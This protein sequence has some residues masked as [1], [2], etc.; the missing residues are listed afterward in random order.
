MN[1]LT[2]TKHALQLAIM[3][4]SFFILSACSGISNDQNTPPQLYSD[5]S[6][7]AAFLLKQA[8]LYEGKESSDWQ[9]S[10]VQALTNEHQFMLAD[11]VIEHLQAKMLSPKQT[12]ELLLL[13]ADNHYAQNELVL[14]LSTLNRIDTSVLSPSAYLHFLKLNVTLQ[15]RN[16]NHQA[17]SDDLL[18]LTPLLTLD[19]EKQQ[20]NDL[21]LRELSLLDASVLN[22]FQ[23]KENLA[24]NSDGLLLDDSSNAKLEQ[25]LAEIEA[26]MD[27]EVSNAIVLTDDQIFVQ[28]W[29]ALASLYQQYQL[30]TN[31]LIRALD[32]WEQTYP[33]H[34]AL[35]FMPTQLRNIPEAAPYLPEKVAVLLPLSGRFSQSAQA[36]QYGISYAFYNKIALK[37]Q[38]KIEHDKRIAAEGVLADTNE[39]ATQNETTILVEEIES[40]TPS[41]HFFDTNKFTMQQISEQ[42]HAQNIDFVIGPLLKPNLEQFLPLAEDIPVL[43]LNSFATDKEAD[44]SLIHYA[45][46]LSPESEA[47][48]AA[49]MMF[50]NHHKKPLVLAPNSKFGKRVSA[51]FEARWKQL[52]NTQHND[53]EMAI[54]S[55]PAETHY[56]NNK[57]QIPRFIDQAM[58]TNAS[59]QRIRQMKAIMGNTLKTEVRSRRDIDAIYIISKRDELILLQPFIAVSISPFA[60]DIPLYASSRSHENDLTNSQNKDLSN[61]TFSDIAFLLD[62]KGQINQ[63]VQAIWPKQSLA[64]LRLFSLGYDSYNLIEQL[65]QLQ[66]IN[67]YH[68]QGLVGEL[69]L[70]KNNTLNSKLD[71]AQYQHGSLVEVTAPTSSK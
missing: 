25:E 53:S 59:K 49:D 61:L 31:Q 21:L 1:A 43:A 29:Y 33:T 8:D 37:Q 22:Q 46:P 28:G 27:V 23:K 58:Q 11:S 10:A 66:M 19:D 24:A 35:D 12:N 6:E 67:G 39:D 63:Q 36:L 13:I 55:Y 14:T 56:F 17:A 20:Y 68:Y 70:D 44:P 15:I 48:Q 50:Q 45:F 2:S 7:K 47:Q 3:A 16:K 18:L 69:T 64:T 54:E 52:N 4:L 38:L 57:Q 71:W 51:A 41:L 30:R 34:P 42:L 32:V 65:K 62:D 60:K 5:F 40:A 9:L 26:E